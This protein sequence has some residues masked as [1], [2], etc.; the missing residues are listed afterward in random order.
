MKYFLQNGDLAVRSTL[1]APYQAIVLPRFF[2]SARSL[3]VSTKTAIYFWEL[4]LFD[5][6][7]QMADVSQTRKEAALV[8]KKKWAKDKK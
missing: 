2:K 3:G 5:F 8:P 6:A 1:F 4:F 7:K